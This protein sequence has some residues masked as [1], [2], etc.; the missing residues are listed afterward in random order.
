[1][2]TNRLRIDL[3]VHT[4][5]SED[6]YVSLKDAVNRCQELNLDGFAITE[7]DLMAEVPTKILEM[8]DLIVVP[9]IEISARGGHILAFNIKKQIEKGLSIRETVT[10]IHYQDGIAVL[11]HPFSVLRT[12]VNK[13]EVKEAGFDLIEAANA[14]QFPYNF[15]LN[16]NIELANELK[17]PMTGGSDAHIPRTVGRAYTILDVENR[18]VEGIIEALR[19]GDTGFQGRGI[20]LSER[21]KL[22]KN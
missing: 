18:K 14:Y 20:S 13:K 6:S 10:R 17:L 5:R 16:K 4:N 11:A 2:P 9:G 1:M 22:I 12:W 7:H 8:T 15:T 19:N 21:F 3:H